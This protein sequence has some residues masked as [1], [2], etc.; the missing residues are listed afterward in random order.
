MKSIVNRPSVPSKPYV[1]LKPGMLVLF[2]Y[3]PEMKTADTEVVLL[4]GEDNALTVV[5]VTT[6]G[7]CRDEIGNSW[8]KVKRTLQS[9]EK[10]YQDHLF[11]FEG[12]VTLSNE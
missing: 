12:S 5:N 7:G 11:P 8:A 10:D 4:V 2:K 1:A 3:E 9:F 6:T